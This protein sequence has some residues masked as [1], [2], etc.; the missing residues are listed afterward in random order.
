L[1]LRRLRISVRIYA[2][3]C[4]DWKH[5]GATAVEEEKFIT[6]VRRSPEMPLGERKSL[7]CRRIDERLKFRVPDRHRVREVE[8]KAKGRKGVQDLRR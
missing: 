3:T 2:I 1:I 8:S 5:I 4:I 6:G 7:L